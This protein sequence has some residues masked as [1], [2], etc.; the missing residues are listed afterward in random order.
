[1]RSLNSAFIYVRLRGVL[2]GCLFASL[3]DIGVAEGQGQDT[4]KAAGDQGGNVPEEAKSLVVEV[5]SY[6][7]VSGAPELAAGIIFG[8][9]ATALYIATAAHVVQRDTVIA[10]RILVRFFHRLK[11]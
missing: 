6:F 1:M 5:R 3:I 7:T 4:V 9:K 11:R 2:A 10:R 8:A